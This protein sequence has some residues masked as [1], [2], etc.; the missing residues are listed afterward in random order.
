MSSCGTARGSASASPSQSAAD[1]EAA[2]SADTSPSRATRRAY[3]LGSVLVLGVVVLWVSEVK[4]LQYVKAHT[5]WNKPYCV[6][7][8]LKGAWIVGLLPVILIP[9]IKRHRLK[10]E[11]GRVLAPHSLELNWATARVC[12]GLSLLV[13]AASIT[14][15]ASLA[16]T[17]PSVNSAIYQ[18]SCVFAYLFSIPL[19][20]ERLSFGKSV[21]VLLA[22]LGVLGVIFSKKQRGSLDASPDAALGDFLVV[23][24]AAAYALKEVLYKRWFPHS[25]LST[26]PVTDAGVCVAVIGALCTLML[27][28]WLLILHYSGVEPFE[29]PPADAARGYAAVAAMMGVYQVGPPP[30]CLAAVATA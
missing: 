22:I 15:V 19:I 5:T 27:P 26:T 10:L 12:C 29:W 7:I 23:C 30:G 6:G 28:L 24:S 25:A 9:R 2:P 8:A 3:L 16:S 14:W 18:T 20:G 17:S 1:V 21:S 13:Q 11:P 4:V